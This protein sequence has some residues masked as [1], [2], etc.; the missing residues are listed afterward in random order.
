MLDEI[1]KE[2]NLK[3]KKQRFFK[4]R[5]SKG[6][7]EFWRNVNQKIDLPCILS[8]ELL[9]HCYITKK[10]F[11]ENNFHYLESNNDRMFKKY[12]AFQIL[13]IKQNRTEQK[14]YKGNLLCG[15]LQQRISALLKISSCVKKYL[16]NIYFNYFNSECLLI[17]LK[18]T[19]LIAKIGG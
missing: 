9:R 1:S 14:K 11:D 4:E 8:M 6:K 18:E 15:K 2:R 5:N 3:G 10:N 7:N 19:L 17:T 12:W 13:I 16:N